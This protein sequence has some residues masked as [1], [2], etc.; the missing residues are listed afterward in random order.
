MT[1]DEHNKTK[2]LIS[3]LCCMAKGGECIA[4]WDLKGARRPLCVDGL[5]RFPRGSVCMYEAG[6]SVYVFSPQPLAEAQ[7]TVGAWE[8][9]LFPL[10]WW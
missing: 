9:G 1:S 8:G 3:S 7:N 4:R 5:L 10:S 6:V 2:L